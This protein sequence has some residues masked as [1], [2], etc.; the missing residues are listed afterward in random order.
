MS[1]QAGVSKAWR[2]IKVIYVIENWFEKV[3]V[4]GSTHIKLEHTRR[5]QISAKNKSRTTFINYDL[6]KS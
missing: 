2:V 4:Q 6:W 5:A 1:K 3:K